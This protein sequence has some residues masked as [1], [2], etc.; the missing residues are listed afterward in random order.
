M[1]PRSMTPRIRHDAI[2]DVALFD[3]KCLTNMSTLGSVR[4]GHSQTTAP[5][6]GRTRPSAQ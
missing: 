6:D 4:Y 3:E 5:A 1:S 2:T